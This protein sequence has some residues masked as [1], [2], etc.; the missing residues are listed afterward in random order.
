M[1]ARKKLMLT[2]MSICLIFMTVSGVFYYSKE[3]NNKHKTMSDNEGIEL[4]INRYFEEYFKS[5]DVLKKPNF[6]DILENNVDNK[7]YIAANELKVEQLKPVNL[8]YK[9]SKFNLDFY[10][11]NIQDTNA[12]V[13]VV[14]GCKFNYANMPDTESAM[15]NIKF[16]FNLEKQRGRWIITKMDTDYDNYDYFKYMVDEKNQKSSDKGKNIDEVKEQLLKESKETLKYL[17]GKKD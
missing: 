2:I 6:K 9:N 13:N 7:L 14:M 15:A 17:G 12:A 10:D 16:N 4:V 11:L 1:K 8:A 5:L 3:K